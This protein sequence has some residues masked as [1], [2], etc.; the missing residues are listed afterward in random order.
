[1]VMEAAWR[2]LAMEL[3]CSFPAA[4][5][6]R[7]AVLLRLARSAAIW[8]KSEGCGRK[9]PS[10]D[11]FQHGEGALISPQPCQGVVRRRFVSRMYLDCLPGNSDLH[12]PFTPHFSG[13]SSVHPSR[14]QPSTSPSAELS[15]CICP[16][17]WLFCSSSLVLT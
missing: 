6:L 14:A 4:S 5:M 16:S 9:C 2:G 13:C 12:P 8:P 7:Q 15:D 1:M 10:Q 3:D 17:S 11:G